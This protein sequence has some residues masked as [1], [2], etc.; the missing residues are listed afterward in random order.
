MT[1]EHTIKPKIKIAAASLAGCFGCHL[2]E[3]YLSGT[4]VTSPR[5]PDDIESP[6]QPELVKWCTVPPC[7]F[8]SKA[9]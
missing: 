2:Q 3:V 9:Q 1:A 5:I 7:S 4:G 8:T 6:L